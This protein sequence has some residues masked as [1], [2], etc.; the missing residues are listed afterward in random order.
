VSQGV[1]YPGLR[2]DAESAV[3]RIDVLAREVA[4]TRLRDG[5]SAACMAA[6]G[7]AAWVSLNGPGELL[8][9]DAGDGTRQRIRVGS[10]PLGVAVGF[11]AVWVASANDDAVR[12]VNPVT[13]NVEDVIDVGDQPLG[14][15]T[16]AGSVWVGNHRDGTVSRIDPARGEV[17]ARIPQPISDWL[18][19]EEPKALVWVRGLASSLAGV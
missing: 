3:S 15:A 12:R 17:V 14:V 5:D 4:T 11:G 7:G 18:R 8:R 19:C 1:F 10:A 13:G 6:G 16:G 2:S 9:I